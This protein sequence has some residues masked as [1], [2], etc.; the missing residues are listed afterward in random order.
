MTPM[1]ILNDDMTGQ[2][3]Q[4]RY[5]LSGDSP[6]AANELGRMAAGAL[7]EAARAR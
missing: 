1:T 6:P 4:D 5:L 7:L 2:T 3:H